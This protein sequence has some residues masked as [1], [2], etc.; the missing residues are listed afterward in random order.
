M[1]PVLGLR[2]GYRLTQLGREALE[3]GAVSEGRPAE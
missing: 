1:S 2:A 3:A